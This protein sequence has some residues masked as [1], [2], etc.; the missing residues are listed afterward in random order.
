MCPWLVQQAFHFKAAVSQEPICSAIHVDLEVP[1]VDHDA[2]TCLA[3]VSDKRALTG[4]PFACKPNSAHDH[5]LAM[6]KGFTLNV[7]NSA[8]TAL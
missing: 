5:G 7:L 8:L 4:Y 1:R 6:E 3:E 2:D